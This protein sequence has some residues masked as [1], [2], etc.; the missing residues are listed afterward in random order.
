ML[1]T[2]STGTGLNAI[3][4]T[5]GSNTTIATAGKD[6]D[7]YVYAGTG[8]TSY[9]YG[10][11]KQNSS[12]AYIT[13]KYNT[14][15]MTGDIRG[16]WNV[17]T[18]VTTFGNE[19]VPSADFSD[20]TPQSGQ[21][22]ITK[23][24]GTLSIVN[25]DGTNRWAYASNIN[26]VAGKQYIVTLTGSGSGTGVGIYINSSQFSLGYTWNKTITYH[27]TTTGSVGLSVFRFGGH[28][29]TGTIT[30]LSVKEA[31]PDRSV[32]GNGLAVHGSPTVSAVA[33]GAELKCIS[34]FSSSNY[35][36][37]PYNSDLDF[38][39]GDF[40]MMG[41]FQ[42]V[43]TIANDALIDRADVG[44]D[45]RFQIGFSG[46]GGFGLYTQDGSASSAYTSQTFLGSAT[47]HF[48]VCVRNS[49]GLIEIYVDGLLSKS[50]NTTSRNITSATGAGVTSIG[51]NYA[52]TNSFGGG[53][54]LPRISATAPSAEQIKE[55]YEAE[56]PM[57]QANAKCTLNGSSDAVTALAYDD[58]T[59]LLHVGTSGGRSVFQ[60]LRRVDETS[61]ST[62]EIAAQGGLIIEET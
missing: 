52:H 22:V 51:V 46:T 41:W 5:N 16:A 28:N 45:K 30:G 34:G 39:T 48:G 59:E 7:L 62:T 60:G 54:A 36:E 53:I 19:L 40:S 11:T 29:G 27:A 24:G 42:E 9:R 31:I 32:K 55:I 8:V 18:D 57:F 15:Y 20:F 25:G 35:L 4:R 26:I 12:V 23:S 33:T 2:S 3:P 37:Q 10:T 14:G 6:N 21:S 1:P 58:S 49:S 47:W 13:S 50:V 43:S 38:G 61:T 56:K 17:D 44:G